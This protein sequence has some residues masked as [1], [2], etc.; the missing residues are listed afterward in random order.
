MLK[1]DMKKSHRARERTAD[2]NIVIVN[3]NAFDS[4]HGLGCVD[5]MSLCWQLCLLSV[6]Y[7]V[8]RLCLIGFHCFT[9]LTR[10]I[11]SNK[12]VQRIAISPAVVF[13]EY[14]VFSQPD[15]YFETDQKCQLPLVKNGKIGNT[16]CLIGNLN[17]LGYMHIVSM[18]ITFVPS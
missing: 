5:L 9:L 12:T 13:L 17:I 7:C 1:K 14:F 10:H 6:F 3:F 16:C 18:M 8:T 4:Y 2:V 15:W 11:Q